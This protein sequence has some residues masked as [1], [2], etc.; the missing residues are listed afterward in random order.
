MAQSTVAN[1]GNSGNIFVP[2]VP[3][4]T[5]KRAAS[6][7]VQFGNGLPPNHPKTNNIK[8]DTV[9]PLVAPPVNLTAPHI[10]ILDPQESKT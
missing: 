2:K 4:V 3:P 8:N 5:L 9:P 7:H 1:V 6:Q 10:V